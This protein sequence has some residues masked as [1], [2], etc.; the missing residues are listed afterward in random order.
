MLSFL[1]TELLRSPATHH[2]PTLLNHAVQYLR[3]KAIKVR[4][5][6]YPSGMKLAAYLYHLLLFRLGG[7][8]R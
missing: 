1:V 8:Q 3:I 6:L 4:N 7:R 2:N 5:G